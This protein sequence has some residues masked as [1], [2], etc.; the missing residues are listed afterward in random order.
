M[1]LISTLH[2][3]T[4][5]RSTKLK[6]LFYISVS[7][8]WK[9]L[10]ILN[11]FFIEFYKEKMLYNDLKNNLFSEKL[12][13]KNIRNFMP[14]RIMSVVE[15]TILYFGVQQMEIFNNSQYF[16]YWISENIYKIKGRTLVVDIRIQ[17]H[18]FNPQNEPHRLMSVRLELLNLKILALRVNTNWN[19]IFWY[20]FV[21][22]LKGLPKSFF[23]KLL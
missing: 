13:K 3:S 16:S 17:L 15:F 19:I 9:Y 14:L 20:S 23:W 22:K 1:L 11:I 2:E 10:L 18:W 12:K 5:T 4:Y 7:N 21:H 8:K 6:F